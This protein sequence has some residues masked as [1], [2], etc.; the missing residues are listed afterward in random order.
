MG[1]ARP[2]LRSLRC[3]P[4]IWSRFR[5]WQAF[6]DPGIDGPG[7]DSNIRLMAS[8]LLPSAYMATAM[9]FTRS[10]WFRLMGMLG[11]R[12]E[13]VEALPAAVGLLTAGATVFGQPV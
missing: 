1:N 12:N 7:L 5:D 10:G 2:R 4:V 13:V 9:F 11:I 3:S 8:M 6:F